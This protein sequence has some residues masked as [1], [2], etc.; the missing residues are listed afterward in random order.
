MAEEMSEIVEILESELQD[1]FEVKNSKSLHRYVVLMV[2][3]FASKSVAEQQNQRFD[4]I[5]AALH[6][7]FTR[8]DERFAAVD[9]RFEDMQRQMDDRFQA[10][11]KQMDERFKAVDKRFEDMQRQMDDRFAA[12]DKRF[13]AVQK[14]ME[15]RFK[16]VDRRFDDMNKRFTMLVTLMSI[17]F[18][19]LAG[20]ITA[21]G[22]FA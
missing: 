3:R 6:A 7:G 19:L 15:E 20:M 8:M 1:A 22:L 14:Q 2:D 21:F 4:E 18:T 11:Q 16:A 12:V 9:Q 10:V 17:F 13:E 5:L